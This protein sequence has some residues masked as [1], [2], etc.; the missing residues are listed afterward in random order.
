MVDDFHCQIITTPKTS[1]LLNFFWLTKHETLE[2]NIPIPPKKQP[3]PPPHPPKIS[4]YTNKRQQF[5]SK[6][7]FYSCFSW[8]NNFLQDEVLST[9]WNSSGLKNTCPWICFIFAANGTKIQTSYSPNGGFFHRDY[10]RHGI[11]IRKKSPRKRNP[12]T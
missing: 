12:S 2:R 6:S 10:L 9:S 1:H 11:R 5:F 4:C 8:S 7:N 3:S